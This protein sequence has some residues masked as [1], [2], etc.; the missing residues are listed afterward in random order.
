M[1]RKTKEEAEITRLHII[2][3]ARRV[4]LQCGVS[5]TSLEKIAAAA[6]VTRGAVYWHFR[7]KSELFFAM[8]EDA[9]LP[10]VDRVVFDADDEDPLAG[11]ETA[12]LEIFRVLADEPKTRETIEIVAFKCEYVDELLPLM[13]C[14]SGQEVFLSDLTQAYTRAAARGL[15]RPGVTPAALATDTFMFVGGLIKHWLGGG[16]ESPFQ[17]D[18][19]QMVRAHVA[20]RRPEGGAQRA[21][22]SPAGGVWKAPG[23]QRCVL[24]S[25]RVPAGKRNS[26][27]GASPMSSADGTGA[28]CGPGQAESTPGSRVLPRWSPGIASTKLPGPSSRLLRVL[29]RASAG[30]RSNH[31]RAN[32]LGLSPSLIRVLWDSCSRFAGQR[33]C[34]AP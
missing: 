25:G 32:W 21:G 20:L 4:F 24:P 28:S 12:L 30:R 18:A 16:P 11:I 33:P 13:G 10:F 8:R 27:P 5:H 14:S 23:S 29:T 22:A 1:V 3:A 17:R 19:E 15:L 2:D 6:G 26:A 9:T 31:T 7:N 34:S